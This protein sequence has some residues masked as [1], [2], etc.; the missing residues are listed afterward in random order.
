MELTE[1][2]RHQIQVAQARVA[3][4]YEQSLGTIGEK[5]KKSV[6]AFLKETDFVQSIYAWAAA[7]AVV[8]GEGD[9]PETRRL[10]LEEEREAAML[11]SATAGLALGHGWTLASFLYEVVSFM[12]SGE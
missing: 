4:A 11:M 10:T 3:R 2:H 12:E 7:Y 8:P 6:S 5:G 9:E 1:S